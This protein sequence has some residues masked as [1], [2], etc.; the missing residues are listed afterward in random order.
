MTILYS[1]MRCWLTS[2]WNHIPLQSENNEAV[3]KFTDAII[4]ITFE[5][6]SFFRDKKSVPTLLSAYKY[7]K[8][9]CIV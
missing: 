5:Q 6:W 4:F 2:S 7:D 3:K 1:F 8:K 9:V